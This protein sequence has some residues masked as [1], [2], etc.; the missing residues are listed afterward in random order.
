LIRKPFSP[1]NLDRVM[2]EINAWGL[3]GIGAM[4]WK[5]NS[6]MEPL[7]IKLHLSLG[8]DIM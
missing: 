6:A 4:E 2:T 7:R 3:G 5:N 8:P 1:A